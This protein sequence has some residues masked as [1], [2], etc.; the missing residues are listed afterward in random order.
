MDDRPDSF[1]RRLE[2]DYEKR[3]L[4]LSESNGMFHL[5]GVLERT[6]G[7]A[8]EAAIQ[9]LS[10]RLGQDDHRT[11]RQRRADALEEIVHPAM[12]RGTLPRRQ[13][14]RP[15]V[16][17]HTTLAGLKREL[18]A[19]ASHLESG[20]PVS[21]K[22]VQ[23]LACDGVPLRVLKADSMGVA[24]GRAKRTA[25]PAQWTALSGAVR[26]LAQQRKHQLTARLSDSPD[27]PP[28]K[29]AV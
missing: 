16:S 8:L 29:A 26:M 14:R 9:S 22:T 25:Q 2:E 6:A 27:T 19:E 23:R 28:P 24:V 11:P 18:G 17:V 15:H 13:G 12:D 3:F 21:S 5:S 20:M 1:D 4:C 7:S 10:G